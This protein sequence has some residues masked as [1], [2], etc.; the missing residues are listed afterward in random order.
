MKNLKILVDFFTPNDMTVYING[1][2]DR[3]TLAVIDITASPTSDLVEYLPEVYNESEEVLSVI[4]S[5]NEM[6][7]QS[8]ADKYNTKY[9]DC[10]VYHTIVRYK[11]EGDDT[12]Y[13]EVESVSYSKD[14]E[15]WCINRV[16]KDHYENIVNIEFKHVLDKNTKELVD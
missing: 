11:E 16:C 14:E 6:D 8:I 15:D 13:E 3:E 10:K 1:I 4:A 12:I 2:D 9:Y 5:I 7:M